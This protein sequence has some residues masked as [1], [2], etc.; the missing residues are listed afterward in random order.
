MLHGTPK[1]SQVVLDGVHAPP[2]VFAVALEVDS[3]S[4]EKELTAALRRLVDED[5]SLELRQDDETGETLL[6]GMG[7]LHLEVAIDHMQRKL[8][9]EVHKSQPRV[10]Y[11]EGITCT[12]RHTEIVN[13]MIGTTRLRGTLHIELEPLLE[14][15]VGNEVMIEDG[16][17]NNEEKDAIRQGVLAALARGAVIGANMM[18]V[19]VE[20]KS[21]ANSDVNG[22]LIG[23]RACASMGVQSALQKCEAVVMEPV[24]RVEAS[25]PE[26]CV[27]DVVSELTHPTRRR[28]V[29]EDV[30]ADGA[31]SEERS[32]RGRSI[33]TAIVPVEGLIGWATKMRSIT[34]G[35]GDLQTTFAEYRKMD[36]GIQARI[37]DRL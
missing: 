19:K 4:D 9:F 28:G 20:V 34:K 35:R 14:Y 18:G 12:V 13:S 8:P 25:V 23:L 32:R 27:G 2:A 21:V 31:L 26:D 29:I 7:E 22:D 33:V 30:T 37:L 17:F 10:A 24:M 6:A 36:E 5:A 3:S 16:S 11:R 1:S 15:G